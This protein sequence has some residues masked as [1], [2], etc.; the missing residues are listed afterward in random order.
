MITALGGSRRAGAATGK[1][2]SEGFLVWDVSRTEEARRPG[3]CRPGAPERTEIY[4]G[5]ALVRVAAPWLRRQDLPDR[6]HLRSGAVKQISPALEE[7]RKDSPKS[8]AK[9]RCTVRRTSR[10]T[11]P[12]F[13]RRR[14]GSSRRLRHKA[15]FL[16]GQLEGDR[17]AGRGSTPT[18]RSAPQTVNDEAIAENGE[19]N[20]NRRHR[21]S[22]EMKRPRLSRS[23]RCQ[24]RRKRP[25]NFYEKGGR[26]DRTTSTTRTINPPGRP[27]RSRLPHLFQRRSQSLRHPRRARAQRDRLV[28]PARP[29]GANRREAEPPGRA[30]G[31]RARRPPRHDLFEREEP[32]SLYSK[33]EAGVA[34][35]G[36]VE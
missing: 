28:S 20:L 11:R 23:S 35:R 18:C 2:F 19:E 33:V 10:A 27:R 30:G 6:R 29:G 13:V 4:D 5:G 22:R 32:G 7:Q 25:K 31:G 8:G 1:D 26:F 36:G 3:H 14:R 17:R 12:I 21:R 34:V 24:R 15:R 9:P 16:A